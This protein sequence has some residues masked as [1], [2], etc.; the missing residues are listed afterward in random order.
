MGGLRLNTDQYEV[1]SMTLAGKTI[2]FRAFKDFQYCEN[3]LD[4]IQKLNLFVP[5][6]YYQNG[7][8]NGYN[9]ETAPIFMPNTVGGYMPGPADEPGI[10][11]RSQKP[12]TLFQALEHGYVA[13]SAGRIRISTRKYRWR[14][15]PNNFRNSVTRCGGSVHMKKALPVKN[16]AC[17]SS[18]SML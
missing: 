15:C 12:N 17:Q 7:T 3:P 9:A 16:K 4:P 1:R 6:A 2:T 13:A 8:I 5:E 10:E 18:I 14:K 11:M